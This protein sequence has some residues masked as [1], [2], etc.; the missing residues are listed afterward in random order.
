MFCANCGAELSDPN[1]KYCQSCGSEVRTISEIQEAETIEEPVSIPSSA[2]SITPSYTPVPIQPHIKVGGAGSHSKKCLGYA[3]TSLGIA[4]ASMIIGG[5]IFLFPMI[6]GLIYFM[7]GMS[8]LRVVGM[9]IIILLYVMGLI[10]G[11]LART[12]NKKAGSLEPINA[13][14]KVGS[15]FAIFG[16]VINAIGLGISF[17]IP[18]IFFSPFVM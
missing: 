2:P 3:L 12:N 15:V 16:I 9:I 17:I 6:T 10:F 1:Q 8:G 7:G 4:V 13:V 5:G 14:N 11:S 18:W